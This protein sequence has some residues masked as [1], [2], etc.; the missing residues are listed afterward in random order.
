MSSPGIGRPAAAVP[1]TLAAGLAASK[2]ATVHT[3]GR[4]PAGRIART[5]RE[6]STSVLLAMNLILVGGALRRTGRRRHTRARGVELRR[7]NAPPARRDT[8]PDVHPQRQGPPHR[9]RSCLAPGPTVRS[10]PVARGK[11]C[12]E[13]SAT[14]VWLLP[15]QPADDDRCL[16][17]EDGWSFDDVLSALR[18]LERYLD[19]TGQWRGA[20]R[21]LPDLSALAAVSP[22]ATPLDQLDGSCQSGWITRLAQA[23]GRLHLPV[24]LASPHSFVQADDVVA[25]PG[26]YGIPVTLLRSG[27]GLP[28]GL[29]HAS[30]RITVPLLGV[31]ANRH[32]HPL[33]Y[34]AHPGTDPRGRTAIDSIAH[35]YTS[36]RG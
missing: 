14:S 4:A 25:T 28:E 36:G 7:R 20:E 21:P 12:G 26:T 2:S 24:H 29:R 22:I 10:R 3:A 34:L 6:I 9:H 35:I 18:R 11:E 5:G 31:A 23:Q 27:I 13:S 15:G 32:H 33:L 16:V 8:G 19:R 30:L 17:L 1:S